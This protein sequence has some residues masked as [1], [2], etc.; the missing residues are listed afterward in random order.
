MSN[1][2]QTKR[3]RQTI[4]GIFVSLFARQI[5]DS[6]IA[7]WNIL[8]ALIVLTILSWTSLAYHPEYLF[9]SMDALLKQGDSIFSLFPPFLLTIVAIF[10]A[11]SERTKEKLRENRKS[12]KE[13]RVAAFL[14]QFVFLVLLSLALLVFSKILAATGVFE[15]KDQQTELSVDAI[16][17]MVVLTD[18][19]LALFFSLGWEILDAIKSLYILILREYFNEE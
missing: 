10:P 12:A 8:V 5:R 19:Y 2:F 15:V 11:F 16:F 4:F 1:N 17:W 14:D 6:R 3:S 9:K 7:Y 13:P 18:L